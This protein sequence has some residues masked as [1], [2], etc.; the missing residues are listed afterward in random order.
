MGD[1]RRRRRSQGRAESSSQRAGDAEPPRTPASAN[2]PDTSKSQGGLQGDRNDRIGQ[3]SGK[4]TTLGALV[5]LLPLAGGRVVLDGTV[6]EFKL[7][8]GGELWASVSPTPIR[9]YPP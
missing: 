9:V 8:D 2:G 7:D 6:D 5:G 1:V 3:Q 4:S